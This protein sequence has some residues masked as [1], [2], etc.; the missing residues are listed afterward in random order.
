MPLDARS[1]NQQRNA[2]PLSLINAR[3]NSSLPPP[4]S[5]RMPRRVLQWSPWIPHGPHAGAN[6]YTLMQVVPWCRR[7]FYLRNEN[8]TL[9]LQV[10]VVYYR[11]DEVVVAVASR[12]AAYFG[13]YPSLSVGRWSRGR[14]RTGAIAID[15][16]S[17]LVVPSTLISALKYCTISTKCSLFLDFRRPR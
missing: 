1:E 17:V 14:K 5:A 13:T 7:E 3:C 15:C 16:A 10:I 11:A 9:V 6:A 8:P 12:Y 4:S 2:T